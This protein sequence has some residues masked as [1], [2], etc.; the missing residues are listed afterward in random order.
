MVW[1]A[2]ALMT[3]A[4][5]LA[6]VW[7]LSARRP[8]RGAGEADLAF[9]RGQLAEVEDDVARGLV[10][11]GDVEATRAE[12]GRRLLTSAEG[13]PG[14]DGPSRGSFRGRR[15]V[16]LLAAVVA[17][18]AVALGVYLRVGAPDQPDMPIASRSA[19]TGLNLAEALPKIEAHLAAD[20]NDGRGFA[21]VAPLYARLGRYDD[22]V[23]AYAAA[24]RLQGDTAER[25]ATLA[26]A[27]MAA[28]DGVV[29]ADARAD[30]DRALA[31][32]P[33]LPQARFFLAVA[34]EQDGDKDRARG[35]WRAL[36][37]D[38]PADAPWREAVRQHLAALSSAPAAS[39]T[40]SPTEM[41]PTG[42]AAAGIAALPPEQRVTAIRGM[43][44]GLATRLAQNG[45]DPEGWL[46]LIRAYTV[47]GESEKAKAAVADA[48]KG[49]DGDGGALGRVDDLA[50]RLGLE[51]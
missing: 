11:P 42:P 47:L 32:D 45:R 34:A 46:R 36:A 25:R 4:V 23:K 37:A 44:D 49:L 50:K 28:A 3:G 26:Q 29:T 33:K 51:G 16:A 19:G 21:L 8:A 41:M 48:R 43:V 18:P 5:A 12:I 14:R 9:Y 13:G 10:T 2:F 6:L 39:A 35:L 1:I 31:Q 15:I 40:D 17:M 7:P 38:S 22:A 20:P 24:I 27:R 30:L